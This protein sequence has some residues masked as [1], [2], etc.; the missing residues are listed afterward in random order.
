MCSRSSYPRLIRRSL[1][2]SSL[3]VP[4]F[5]QAWKA[6]GQVVRDPAL[7]CWIRLEPGTVIF[8]NNQ[9]VLHG[10]SAFRASSGRMLVGCYIRSVT[11]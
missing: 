9:R 1:S 11:S 7:E 5:Y 4:A 2:L 8:I 6:L 10:R 3:Q